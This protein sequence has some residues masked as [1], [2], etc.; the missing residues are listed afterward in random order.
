VADL[1]R[2]D[3]PLTQAGGVMGTPAYMSPEQARGA[4]AGPTADVYALGAVGYFLL[5][6]RPPFAGKNPLELLHAHRSAAA[7]PPSELAPAVPADLEAAVLRCLA[8]DPA[9]R[10]ATAAELDAALAGCG[11]AGGWAEADAAAWWDAA[12]PGPNGPA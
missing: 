11:C 3:E 10:F 2:A 8:K 7:V 5:T 4:D 1:G 6:G 9:G 12:Q